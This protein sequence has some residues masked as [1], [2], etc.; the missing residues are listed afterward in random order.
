M[1]N[2]G[3]DKAAEATTTRPTRGAPGFPHPQEGSDDMARQSTAESA[4]RRDTTLEGRVGEVL[5]LL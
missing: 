3:G 4:E 5:F 2:Q 1:T